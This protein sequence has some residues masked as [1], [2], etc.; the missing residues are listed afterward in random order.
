M[1]KQ[2]S[3][4]A[5]LSFAWI[6]ALVSQPQALRAQHGSSSITNQ[7][8]SVS[9]IF[10][11]PDVIFGG[12]RVRVRARAWDPDG[13]VAAVQFYADGQLIGV[14][15]NEPFNLVWFFNGEATSLAILTAVAVDNLGVTN[16]SSG[17][18]LFG[19]QPSQDTIFRIVAPN[20]PKKNVNDSIVLPAKV[21]ILFSARLATS[22]GRGEAARFFIDNNF[23][24]VVGDPPYQITVT[25]LSDGPH[26]LVVDTENSF[27]LP[28]FS[29][30]G[31]GRNITIVPLLIQQA[32][33]DTNHSFSFLAAGR[34]AGKA[35]VI[36]ASTNLVTWQPIATNL[37]ST[38]SFLFTDP[39]A[40][41][42]SRRFYRASFTQ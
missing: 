27:N 34:V 4:L 14:V 37:T 39:Q 26:R 11:P 32:L 38:N 29:S 28:N 36:E 40:T 23:V 9:I 12:A 31:D 1:R 19:V 6:C 10:P 20:D 16:T 8:P 22:T 13:T 5:F 7:P 35:T 18:R 41:N 15:T 25:N 30:Y 17:V 21:D 2:F 3:F 33:T 42:F 24:A